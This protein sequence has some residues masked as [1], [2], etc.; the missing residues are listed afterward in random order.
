MTRNGLW[1]IACAFFIVVLAVS[2]WSAPAALSLLII[3][4]C[5][6]LVVIF[7]N[8]TNHGAV[9]NANTCESCG[10]LLQGHAGL[11]VRKCRNC[12]QQQSWVK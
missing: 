4:G 7:R 12:G 10:A 11:P 6:G 2:A 9:D 3:G 8:R 5:L 1:T